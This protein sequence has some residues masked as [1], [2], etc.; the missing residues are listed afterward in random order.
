MC[1]HGSVTDWIPPELLQ[2]AI[3]AARKAFRDLDPDEVPAVLRRIAAQSGR[4]LPPPLARKL[5]E[6]LDED[7]WLREKTAEAGT[8]LDPDSPDPARAVSALFLLRPEGWEDRAR[9]A[10]EHRATGAQQALAQT[11]KRT[12]ADLEHQLEAAREKAKAAQQRAQ[13]AEIDAERKAQA[14]RGGIEVA[15]AEE[16]AAVD[17]LRRDHDALLERYQRLVDD[18]EEAGD[19]ITSLRDELLRA[20]R[21]GRDAAQST[22]PQMWATRDPVDIA[23]M[24]DEIVEAVRPDAVVVGTQEAV[25]DAPAFALP[26]GVSPDQREAM[27]WLMAHEEPY[28]LVVD[29]YNVTFLL[30]EDG[31]TEMAAR[32]RLNEG[33]ARFR[34]AATAPVQ[35]I[36]VY[37]SAQSGGV[38]STKG[39]GGIEIR[40][41]EAGHTADEE[42]L[43]TALQTPAR[44]AVVSTDRRVREGA[45][46]SGALGLWSQALVAWLERR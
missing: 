28:S 15:R 5:A 8:D 31:F 29:G 41:T 33:L 39:P 35:V 3:K 44:L 34:R 4:R 38:T 9:E 6:R 7:E 45:E 24:L 17:G 20:R 30:D 42:I 26:V 40:F 32:D 14:A 11:L 23:R 37:D 27:A 18:L 46:E 12:I 1:H 13:A 36:V 10:A 25:E 16:R 19:R 43:A 22:G 2:P 21:A